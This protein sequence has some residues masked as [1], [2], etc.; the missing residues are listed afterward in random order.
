MGTGLPRG[1][2]SRGVRD[3]DGRLPVEPVGDPGLGVRMPQLPR[4]IVD[5][6]EPMG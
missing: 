3:V 4:A 1:E 2:I 5:A 6:L